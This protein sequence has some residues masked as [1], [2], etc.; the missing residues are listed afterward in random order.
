MAYAVGQTIEVCLRFDLPPARGVRRVVATFENERG[1]VAEFTEVPAGASE[2]VVQEPSQI[3]LQGRADYPGSYELKRLR[4][5]H[6]GGVTHVDPPQI[7]FEVRA[8]PEV[9]VG[10]HLR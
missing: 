10:G 9:A 5:E 7:G 4:V 8:T 2:C 3:G 6:L 1:D